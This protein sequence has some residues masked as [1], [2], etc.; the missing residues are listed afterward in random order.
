MPVGEIWTF[1][2][3]VL[4]TAQQQPLHNDLHHNTTDNTTITHYWP[5][6]HFSVCQFG[7]GLVHSADTVNFVESWQSQLCCF[8]PRYTVATKSKRR[9]T[10]GWQKSP[11]FDKV[12][13]VQHVQLGD[14]VD[15]EPATVDRRFG[16]YLSHKEQLWWQQLLGI[17]IRINLI[18]VQSQD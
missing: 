2:E 6:Y 18:S 1:T 14:N 12:V 10:F 8:G 5:I 13:R 4:L 9:S 11:T 7:S 15:R 3:D 17:F 16:A